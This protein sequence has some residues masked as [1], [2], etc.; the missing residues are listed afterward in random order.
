MHGHRVQA[1]AVEVVPLALERDELLGPEEPEHLD[2]LLDSGAA[3][4]EFLVECLV[5]HPVSSDSHAEAKASAREQIELGALL[6]HEHGLALRQDQDAGDQLDALCH[7]AEVAEEHEGLVVAHVV[8]VQLLA[9]QSIRMPADH[10]LGG[11]EVVEA[12][13]FDR[14]RELPEEAGVVSEVG[15]AERDAVAHRSSPTP[16]RT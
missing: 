4:R 7:R 6:R 11:N 13:A 9:G 10:V 5:L 1:H 16:P 3:V 8:G 14:L 12:G 15:M 2:L